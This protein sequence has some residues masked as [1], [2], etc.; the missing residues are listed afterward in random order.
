MKTLVECSCANLHKASKDLK[1]VPCQF[2][3]KLLTK[4]K[5]LCYLNIIS[6][7]KY[8][9]ATIFFANSYFL[10]Y[11]FL[12][13]YLFC[14]VTLI[15]GENNLFF[16]GCSSVPFA[17]SSLVS[18]DSPGKFYLLFLPIGITIPDKIRIGFGILDVY[19]K[20]KD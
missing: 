16:C 11:Y 10:Y 17:L 7:L 20:Q 6:A 13:W 2:Q 5:D 1:I 15:I 8:N 12:H 18:S 9:Q 4:Q 19:S 14:K 3:P